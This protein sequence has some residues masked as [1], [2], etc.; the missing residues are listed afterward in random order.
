M[1][2]VASRGGHLTEVP[3]IDIDF[4]GRILLVWKS[5]RVQKM[6]AQGGSLYHNMK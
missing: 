5:G 1:V 6:V 2:A 3:I 4:T